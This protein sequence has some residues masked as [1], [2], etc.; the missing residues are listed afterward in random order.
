M[1]S[2]LLDRL[3]Q[4]GRPVTL[5]F[6]GDHRPSIPGA[7]EPGRERHTPYVLLRFAA[8]GQPIVGEGDD[9]DLTPAAL[10]HAILDVICL[11]EAER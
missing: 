9:C 2:R 3:P 7:S 6:F 1:L 5:C 4:M 11:G 8:D 10:H